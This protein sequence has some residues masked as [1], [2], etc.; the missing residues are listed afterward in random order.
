M[1]VAG[2]ML[3]R[4]E[5]DVIEETVRHLATQ[6]DRI[7]VY[8]NRSKDG[9]SLILRQL[10]R[11]LPVLVWPDPIVGHYQSK[12]ITRL[13]HMARMRGYGWVVPCDADELWSTPGQTVKEYLSTLSPEVSIVQAMLYDYLPPKSGLN[14]WH[15][16]TA[17]TYRN[18]NPGVLPKVAV[19]THR[20]L[21][22]HE[23]NHGASYDHEVQTYGGLVIRHFTWRS[24]E[25]YLRKIRNGL[26]SFSVTD[27]DP[28]FG[29]HW[30][31]FEG[32][33]DEAIVEHYHRHF[34]RDYDAPDAELVY[35]PV[36]G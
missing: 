14:G 23:G 13:A 8:D 12:K 19:R 2:L 29:A 26:E 36:G 20:S 17:I 35:D 22:I 3:V 1:K 7:L 34:T 6:V 27:L 25:Q 30:R 28:M 16:F 5:A 32:A 24:P 9:T 18:R 11:E 21:V 33:T 10:T 15:P 31:M 4:D